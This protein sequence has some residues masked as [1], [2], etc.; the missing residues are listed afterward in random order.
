MTEPAS[1]QDPLIGKTLRAYRIQEQIGV[2]RWGKVYRA[3]QSS[4]NRTAAVRVLSPEIAAQP[5]KT[6]QFL[7]ESS[8]DARMIHPHLVLVYEAGPA[9]GTYFCA[10]EYMDGPPLPEFLRD[11]DEVDEHRLLQTIIGVA[12]ALDFLWHRQVP[13]QPPL[14]KNVLTATDGTVKLIN[15]QPIEVPPSQSPQEDLL[16]LGVMVATLANNIAPVSKPI[17]ELVE[18]M[19]GTEG[20]EPFASLAAVADGAEALDQELFSPAESAGPMPEKSEPKG[21][22]P[23]IVIVIGLLVLL[24]IGVA[25]WF[26]WRTLSN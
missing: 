25:V 12:R 15:I 13:H 14:G 2:S 5:G 8:A 10:M 1:G 24:L 26:T 23:L 18:R 7:E 20:R 22:K 17:S 6:E 21:I 3:F 9:E 11:G 19:L 4:I 16:K